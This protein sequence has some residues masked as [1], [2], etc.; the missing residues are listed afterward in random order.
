[1]SCIDRANNA[2]WEYVSLNADRS[3]PGDKGATIYEADN[4]VWIMA[5][6]RKQSILNE[7]R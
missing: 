7:C 3:K 5:E 6:L 2:Y 4:E 1:M